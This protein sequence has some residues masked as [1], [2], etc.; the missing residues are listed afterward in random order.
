MNSVQCEAIEHTFE[1]RTNKKYKSIYLYEFNSQVTTAFREIQSK[2]HAL[3]E[4]IQF[5]GEKAIQLLE[6]EVVAILKKKNR[7]QSRGYLLVANNL[8]E[9][10]VKDDLLNGDVLPKA[11]PPNTLRKLKKKTNKQEIHSSS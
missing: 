7:M 9:L 2:P 10:E 1:K 11:T 4:V 3:G 8:L 6:S 5:L